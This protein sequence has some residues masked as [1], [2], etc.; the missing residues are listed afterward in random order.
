MTPRPLKRI[1]SGGELSR[2]MLAA[3]IVLGSEDGI[4]TLVFDEIDAGVGGSTARSLASVLAALAR[5][6]QVIVVT[7]T[8]QIA[9]CADAHYVVSKCGDDVPETR[10]SAC[11][12]DDRV[13]EVA[14]ML[15]GDT[16]K[17]SLDHARALLEEVAQKRG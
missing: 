1:A 4:D 3:S 9:V 16:E 6:H 13:R 10:L 14:R 5:T 11:R 17:A 12:G 7:H 15:S 2:I 8:A